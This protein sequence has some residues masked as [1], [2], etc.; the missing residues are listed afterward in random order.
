VTLG[1]KVLDWT[2]GQCCGADPE[3]SAAGGRIGSSV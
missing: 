1:G 3:E 2:T